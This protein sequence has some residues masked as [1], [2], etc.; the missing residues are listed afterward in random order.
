MDEVTFAATTMAA[1]FLTQATQEGYQ[2]VREAIGRLIR[3]SGQEDDAVAQLERLDRDRTAVAQA[4]AGNSEAILQAAAIA[5]APVL[6]RLADP[7]P[8]VYAEL[9]ALARQDR[10][11]SVVNQH[12]HGTGTFINGNVEGALTINHGGAGHGR[13]D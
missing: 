5:W 8:G 10:P 6:V 11:S 13:H 2:R 4:P 1:A 3:R 12:N 7:E 9:L